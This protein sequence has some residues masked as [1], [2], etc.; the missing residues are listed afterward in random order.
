MIVRAFHNDP[1]MADNEPSPLSKLKSLLLSPRSLAAMAALGVVAAAGAWGYWRVAV[2]PQIAAAT[3]RFESHNAM[4]RLYELQFVY[5]KTHDSYA[6]DLDSLLASAPDGPQLRAKLQD[7]T[8]ITTLAVIGDAD[9]FRL[10]ANV[11]DPERTLVK[12]RGPTGG[13]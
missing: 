7:T 5:R 12:F 4:M 8:D 6:K 10:E 3:M 13:R 11:R 1:V 2:K 9:R